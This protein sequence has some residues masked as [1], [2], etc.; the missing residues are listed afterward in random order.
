MVKQEPGGVAAAP[1]EVEASESLEERIAELEDLLKFYKGKESALAKAERPLVEVRLKELKEQ[2]RQARPLPA[3]LQAATDRVART[4][5]LCDETEA[6][7][8]AACDALKAARKEN[9]EAQ[10]KKL[11]ALQELEEVKKAAGAEPVVVAEKGLAAGMLAAL[12]ARNIVGADA[13]S[14]LA[15]VLQFYLQAKAGG[16]GAAANPGLPAGLVSQPAGT[17][18]AALPLRVP[19]RTGGR[20]RSLPREIPV[21]RDGSTSRSP[22]GSRDDEY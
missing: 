6:K 9:E 11:A 1:M 14:L 5:Q 19:V 10:E 8:A 17:Q 7:V 16:G 18:G 4:Q 21:P 13:D 22:R 3:R 15:D 12:A 2:Q 20:G